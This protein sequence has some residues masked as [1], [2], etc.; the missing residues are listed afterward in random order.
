MSRSFEKRLERVEKALAQ[1]SA[2]ECN[3]ADPDAMFIQRRG[4]DLR[5]AYREELDLTCPVHPVRRVS[6]WLVLN[7]VIVDKDG[8][9]RLNSPTSPEAE[10]YSRLIEEYRRRRRAQFEAAS[11][12]AY[13]QI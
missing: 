6:K 1:R 9:R 7:I 2:G 4:I 11:E 5:Q 3:C 12:G 8:K 13:D 10:E